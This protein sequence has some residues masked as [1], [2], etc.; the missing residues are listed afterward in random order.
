MSLLR[1]LYNLVFPL[2]FLVLLPG[3][4]RRMVRR[5]NYRRAFGQRLGFYTPEVRARLANSPGRPWIQAV[6]VG[7]MLVALKL[8]AAWRSRGPGLPLILSTT[9]TTGFALAVERAGPGV[10]VIYTPI[11]AAGCVR[12][13]FDA[14]QPGRVVIVDG[15][16]WPNLLW[17]ARARRVH[18]S[19]VNARLSPRS[20]RR[21]RRFSLA[22]R[23]IMELLDLVCVADAGDVA[24]WESLGVPAGRV[25][26]TGSVKFDDQ[27]PSP[28]DAAGPCGKAAALHAYLGQL[29]IGAGEPILLA[30]S[31]HPGEERAVCDAFVRLRA[32]FPKLFLILA[33]RHVERAGALLAELAVFDLR[34]VARSQPVRSESRP[35]VLLLDTTGEL[36]DWYALATLVFIG[37]S[38]TAV[39]GQNPM[40]AIAASRPVLFGPRMDNFHDL[41]AELLATQGAVQ[42][43]DVSSLAAACARLLADPA[44][45]D[46]QASAASRLLARHAGAAARTVDMLLEAAKG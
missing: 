38:L 8:I 41:A 16:L 11:D 37:K 29:G 33:P 42:V 45:R 28:A 35:D 7:E 15:G 39:G 19:L 31:T 18:V 9:T 32:R 5:G 2:A 12:R 24:R 21:W 3:Y 22:A 46:R 36:R 1:R 6:S 20:E 40:E 30:G 17:T 34:L 27:P 13:A 14:L 10:E 26:Q 25:K 23:P 44:A 43:Q 4:L